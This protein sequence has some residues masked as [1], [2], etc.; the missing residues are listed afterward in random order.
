MTE[1]SEMIVKCAAKIILVE[2][3]MPVVLE[4]TQTRNLAEHKLINKDN[5]KTN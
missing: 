5:L 3:A 4:L 2:M 1:K